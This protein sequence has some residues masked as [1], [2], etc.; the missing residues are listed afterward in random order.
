ML[1]SHSD[2]E[3]GYADARESA[4][5]LLLSHARHVA[6]ASRNEK[7]EHDRSDS[8]EHKGAADVDLLACLSGIVGDTPFALA[9]RLAH[10]PEA[11]SPS[12]VLLDRIAVSAAF[13]CCV[14]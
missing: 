7:N 14:E 9:I 2:L 5:Q 4:R 12:K 1:Y 11:F 3:V 10:A 13:G 8:K 6:N